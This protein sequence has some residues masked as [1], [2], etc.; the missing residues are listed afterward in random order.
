MAGA[1]MT[2]AAAPDL[3]RLV[4]R[5]H[6]D[7][8]SILGAHPH[9][10]GVVVRAFR[11][12]A[13]AVRVVPEGEDAVALECVH[14]GGVFEGVVEGAELSLRYHLE[15][16]YPDA[17]TVE[18]QDPY[19]FLPTIGELDLHLLGEGR[20]EELWER[21]GAHVRELDGVRGTSFAVWAPNARAVSVVGDFNFWDGRIHPM[22]S[23]G[24]SGIWELFLPGVDSGAT[25]KYEILAPDDEIRLKA[26]PVAFAAEV[27]PK[28]ASVVW[29]PRHRWKDAD[30][31]AR[32][33]QTI[34]LQRPMSIYEVHLG[35]WRLNPMEGNRSLSYLELADELAAYALDMGF[36]HLELLPVMA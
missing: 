28:T 15:V 17:G 26:D 32:R 5:E 2:I 25:Y 6:A 9:D 11:P 21:L 35:S 33:A 18:V 10:G 14:P 7:P 34:P 8:H 24:A 31:L 19:R 23:L 22:R 20:H 3:E 29:E 1:A 12:A 30:W 16:D 13:S 4:R 27:P 36:T